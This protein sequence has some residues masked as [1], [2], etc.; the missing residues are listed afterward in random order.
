MLVGV[1]PATTDEALAAVH[2]AVGRLMWGGSVELGGRPEV[3]RL[4]RAGCDLALLRNPGLQADALAPEID[5]I[6]EVEEEWSDSL[7]RAVE[8]L[9]VAAVLYRVNSV[10]H[11]TIQQLIELQRVVLLVRKPL[12]ASL[13][14][15]IGPDSLRV[16]RDA[17]VAGIMV[18]PS[19]VKD[20]RSALRALP[21]PKKTR[22]K[23]DAIVPAA[24][25]THHDHGEEDD[26]D[27]ANRTA[28]LG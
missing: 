9:P 1:G 16:L 3:Q 17:G 5:K 26:E 11:L 25:T 22:D 14:P 28:P 20:F 7:L 2:E 15:S 12:I 18:V 13:A 21:P 24:P 4:E 27:R 6:L 10:E 8:A 19:K 23:V